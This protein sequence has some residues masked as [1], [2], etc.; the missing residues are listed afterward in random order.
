MPSTASE[1]QARLWADVNRLLDAGA[2]RPDL[3]VVSGSLTESGAVREFDEASTFLT[4]LRAL[5]GLEP[6]RCI[7]VPG[8]DDLTRLACQA[9]FDSCEADDIAPQP[10]YWPKWRHFSRTFDELYRDLDGVTFEWSQPWTVYAV[11]DLRVVIAGLNS[12]MAETHR[13]EDRHGELGEGQAAWF[14]EQLRPYAEQGWLRLAAVAHDPAVLRDSPATAQLLSSRVNLL[15]HGQSGRGL[16]SPPSGAAPHDGPWSAPL[17]TVPAGSTGEH[18][19]VH[20]TADGVTRWRAGNMILRP[21][22]VKHVWQSAAATFPPGISPEPPA[23]APGDLAPPR[24]RPSD[25][26]RR[27]AS[28]LEQLLDQ[29]V[30]VI[31]AAHPGARVRRIE[32][33]DGPSHLL[34]TH[35]QEGF[36]HQWRVAA[37]VGAITQDVVEAFAAQVHSGEAQGGAELVRAGPRP[38]QQLQSL[39]LR[40]G[41]RLRTFTEFQGLLDL[42]DYVAGQ[43]TRLQSDQRY[44]HALYVPQRYRDLEA[45]SIGV[46]ENVVEDLLRELAIDAGRFVLVLGD[47]GRGKTFALREL[48]RQ[49]PARLPHLIPIYVELRELDK[50]HSVDALV[51]AHLANHGEDVIDLKAFRYML[52]QGRIVLLFDG[53]DE[54]ATRV[55][56]DRAADHLQALVAAAEGK[57]KIV[58]ASRTQHFRSQ[59]QVFTA[60]GERVGQLPSRLVVGIEDFTSDQVRSYLAH[61]YGEERA[62]EER[63]RLIGSIEDLPALSSNPRML[64]FIAALD[65]DRLSSVAGARGTLSAAG[66]YEV[67]LDAWLSYEHQRTQGIPGAPAGLSLDAL[68]QLVTALAMRL[69]DCGETIIRLDDLTDEVAASLAGL[70][71]GQLTA[72]QGAHAIG[73][74]SLLV[75]GE[76]GVFGFIHSSVAEWLVARQIAAHL[77]EQ[78]GPAAAL[79]RRPLSPLTID[80][81]CDLAAPLELRQWVIG[82]LEDPGLEEAGTG[83]A[84][85]ANALRLNARMRIP[86]RCDLRGAQ[87]RGEDLSHR[88]FGRSTSPGPT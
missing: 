41:I 77:T 16:E 38:G 2:P 56:Y 52:Q 60:V 31:E 69:N 58:V 12:T 71:D 74:G 54:L 26:V 20:L 78:G 37:H 44:P 46:R 39:A 13:P 36:G 23:D 49:I 64:S 65:A 14:A 11:P 22:L 55:T 3:I 66:L 63:L 62:A 25:E 42:R 15:L 4:G 8:S 1:L 43:A 32:S 68:W 48:A 29:M 85:R 47:F 5:L 51:A 82:V 21:E 86:A 76:D 10:P 33:A 57:A 34:I 75:R 84:A 40:R 79:E 73:A 67:I 50:A 9:Y 28:P 70:A 81:L 80:F 35:F 45:E 61:L 53:F 27:V 83:S 19:I 18:E 30:E 24:Q 87:L 59:E 6:D 88:E 7:I 72:Q 17:L